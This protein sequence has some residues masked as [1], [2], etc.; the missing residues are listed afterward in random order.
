MSS[1]RAIVLAI[2]AALLYSLS[3]PS[4]KTLLAHVEPTMLAALLYL[5]AGVG[6]S[7][8]HLG[9]AGFGKP[10]NAR[11]LTRADAVYAVGM[12]VLDIAA[13]ILLL[14]GVARTSAAS[15]SLLSNFEIVATSLIALAVFRERISFRLWFGISL[16]VAASVLL[17]IDM[18]SQ[19]SGL[20]G[21]DV[22]ALFVLAACVC[23]GV[24]N[25]FT[26]SISNKSAEQIVIIKGFGSGIGIFCVALILGN[27]IPTLGWAVAA[28][29]LGFMA[30]GLSISCYIQA[31]SVLGAAKTSAYYAVA[32][33]I[34]ALLSL[35]FLAERPPALF[36][37]ALVVMLAAT[38]VITRD[39]I[40]A[41]H[42]H[43]HGHA[44]A[45]EHSHGELVHTHPHTHMHSHYHAH[46][47]SEEALH[48]HVHCDFPDHDH[49]F[50]G[51]QHAE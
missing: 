18:T 5:G 1:R 22:G 4:S 49:D 19:A 13:P 29:A 8:L 42:T 44:H 39:T 48:A 34:G 2:F 21:V 20:A 37:V 12:V 50:P 7:V 32:P 27:T 11:P 16:T 41:Q 28:M 31:Q 38:A 14:L 46:V 3:I 35:V 6:M 23:W 40:G 26:R 51:H 10:E 24:E 17:S 15:A 45:H 25:N 47:A 9:R 30:Y 33:F 43:E 36:Y